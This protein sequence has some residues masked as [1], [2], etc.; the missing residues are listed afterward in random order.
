MQIWPHAPAHHFQ[1]AG[2][3]FIIAATLYKE[4][5]FRTRSR[6]DLLETRLFARAE[7]HSCELQAWALFPNHYHLVV[8][9]ANVREMIVRFHVETALEINRLDDQ[10]GRRVWYQFWD[11]ELTF[12]RS[13]LA[14]LRYTHENAVHHGIV[15]NAEK[16]RWC[17]ASWFA[18]NAR[19]SFVETVRRI[20]IDR[21]N[22]RDDFGMRQR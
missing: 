22:V 3:Y 21:V 13:W 9:G 15:A 11:T 14:R 6:L 16:Y 17:S 7:Q 10:R 12:E 20:K 18:A 2:T 19:P 4:R 5:V 8:S 1:N